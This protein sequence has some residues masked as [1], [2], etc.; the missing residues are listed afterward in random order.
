MAGNF[1]RIPQD[2]YYTPFRPVVPLIPHIRHIAAYAEPCFG[3]GRLVR[4][5]AY[6]GKTCTYSA[7]LDGGVD[8]LTDPNLLNAKTII[9]NPPYKWDVLEPMIDRFMSICETWL[10]LE[11]DF[12]ANA[13]TARFMHHCVEVVPVGKI[14]WFEDTKDESQKH[15]AW[16]RFMKFHFAGTR[17]HARVPVARGIRTAEDHAAWQEKQRQKVELAKKR[18]AAAHAKQV[19]AAAKARKAAA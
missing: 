18:E 11:L 3:D 9:T 14:R 6:F 2:R 4:H 17:L 7:D 1:E 10:L 19:A 8:A 12:L 15:Y 5:L 13:R 16:Y